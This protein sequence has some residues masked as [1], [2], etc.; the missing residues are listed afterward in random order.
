MTVLEFSRTF[1]TTNLDVLTE[2]FESLPQEPRTF[3]LF[4]RH[5]CTPLIATSER[6][7]EEYR[8]ICTEH[9]IIPYA[10]LDFHGTTR[11][12]VPDKH[13]SLLEDVGRV[14]IT[15]D[16]LRGYQCYELFFAE[17]YGTHG[18][19]DNFS[20][21]RE[22]HWPLLK[23]QGY[24]VH[25]G[26]FRIVDRYRNNVQVTL[27]SPYSGL[28]GKV[29]LELNQPGTN[30]DALELISWHQGLEKQTNHS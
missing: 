9:R 19:Q 15:R 8:R 27:F 7:E 26:S 30:D 10:A 12:F 24:R 29:V 2:A 25:Q 11:G 6:A 4:L 18:A 23:E 13:R 1:R 3:S 22:E 28:A 16:L 5:R 17:E 20:R 21:L 14:D